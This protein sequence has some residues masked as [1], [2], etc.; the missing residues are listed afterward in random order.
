MK[1]FVTVVVFLA[2]MNITNAQSGFVHYTISAGWSTSNAK[3]L[4]FTVE[5]AGN[6]KIHTGLLTEA[7]FY[8]ASNIKFSLGSQK[9]YV[10]AGL[11]LKTCLASSRNF[12]QQV[13]IGGNI[14]S[15]NKTTI[16]FPYLGF[17][18]NFFLSPHAQFVLAQ[19]C[20]YLFGIPAANWQPFINIGLRMSH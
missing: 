10:S 2:A 17:E 7:V 18:Q 9:T 20:L 11:F 5:K 1:S 3:I 6:Q 12:N 13:Y 15:D 14:G 4:D 19:K 16:W 8:N